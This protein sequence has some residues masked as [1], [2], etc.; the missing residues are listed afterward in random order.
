[1]RETDGT[2]TLD[3]FYDADGLYGFALNGAEYYYLRNGQND[4]TGI[5]DTDGNEVVSYRYDT[6]GKLLE[7]T[8]PL[9]ETVGAQNPYRYR[10]YR[11]DTETGLYYLNSRYY[12]PELGRFI[13]ADD[14]DIPLRC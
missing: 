8:G 10:G 12:D 14:T 3:Y 9:A 13:N 7:I 2:D 4:I 11:Y 1:M 6:W 5:L